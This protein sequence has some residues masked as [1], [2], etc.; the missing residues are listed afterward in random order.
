M[1]SITSFAL[2]F[3]LTLVFLNG[4]A[5]AQSASGQDR[6]E[7]PGQPVAAAD[8]IEGDARANSGWLDATVMD[9][10]GRDN[11][12]ALRGSA[13]V[14]RPSG[15][16]SPVDTPFMRLAANTMAVDFKRQDRPAFGVIPSVVM[17]A[18]TALSL[19]TISLVVLILFE[20][21]RRQP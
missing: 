5:K 11:A 10:T 2:L 7:M 14:A 1:R 8:G 18:P 3:M 15:Q 16:T 12:A 19:L 13:L 4:E 9:A 17:R 20:H 6:W 21:R